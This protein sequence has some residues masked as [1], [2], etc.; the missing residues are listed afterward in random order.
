[1]TWWPPR[2]ARPPPSPNVFLTVEGVRCTHT[3]GYTVERV[4]EWVLSVADAF[5]I[6]LVEKPAEDPVEQQPTAG[7]A[8]EPAVVGLGEEQPAPYTLPSVPV[9]AGVAAAVRRCER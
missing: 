4:E 1:M 2:L 5:G 6:R 8:A 9:G 3:Q 7:P